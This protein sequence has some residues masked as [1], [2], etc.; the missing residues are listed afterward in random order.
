MIFTTVYEVN[1]VNENTLS[2]EYGGKTSHEK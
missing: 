1:I 2:C